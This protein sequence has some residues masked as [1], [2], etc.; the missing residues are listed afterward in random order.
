MISPKDQRTPVLLVAGSISLLIQF[1][2]NLLRGE[3]VP[4]IYEQ[5]I[6]PSNCTVTSSKT[7]GIRYI[8]YDKTGEQNFVGRLE[9][10]DD[11]NS[12]VNETAMKRGCSPTS[13]SSSSMSRL[14]F[15]A[16]LTQYQAACNDAEFVAMQS[17]QW[18][19][20][21]VFELLPDSRGT[22]MLCSLM[23]RGGHVEPRKHFQITRRILAL[24]LLKRPHHA[25]S[26]YRPNDWDLDFWVR[27][28][29]RKSWADFR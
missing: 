17:A 22:E 21:L 18:G 28:T 7:L 14:T 26:T 19:R 6:Q 27:G 29:K 20:K 2:V 11:M 24:N 4:S 16:F 12:P 13:S 23:N 10:I 15:R 3:V 5:R 1:L 25:Y 9:G 8:W